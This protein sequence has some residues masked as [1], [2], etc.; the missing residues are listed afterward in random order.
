MRMMID[1]ATAKYKV[2]AVVSAYG[3]R[4]P[5]SAYSHGVISSLCLHSDQ[6]ENQNWCGSYFVTFRYKNGAS[7]EDRIMEHD[8][9]PVCNSEF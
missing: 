2:G 3:E 4:N 9:A 7:S 6:P 5:D 1:K 8:L